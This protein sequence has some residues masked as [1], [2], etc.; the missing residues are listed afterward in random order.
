MIK[1]KSKKQNNKINSLFSE[2]DFKIKI[3]FLFLLILTFF[4]FIFD[5]YLYTFGKDIELYRY[6]SRFKYFTNQTVFSI[7]FILFSFFVKIKNK[8]KYSF[9]IYGTIVNGLLTFFVY[10]LLLFPF[11]DSEKFIIIKFINSSKP[12]ELKYF[13]SSLQHIFI[14]LIYFFLF[15]FYIPLDLKKI[16]EIYYSFFHPILYLFTFFIISCFYRECEEDLKKCWFPYPN[17]QCPNHGWFLFKNKEYG[18]MFSK[19]II[20]FVRLSILFFL[21][22]ILFVLIF[23]GKRKFNKKIRK[24]VFKKRN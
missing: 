8:K 4:T 23:I 3:Y 5:I 2:F 7:L 18:S 10:N 16:K 13:I 17:I 19:L 1:K 22:S 11:Y 15:F 6:Y 21:F 24:K 12:E 9:F 20:V 14:P